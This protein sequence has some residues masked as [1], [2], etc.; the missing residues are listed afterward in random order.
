MK[1]IAVMTSGGDAPG[2][3]AAVRAIVRTASGFG[4]EVYGFYR[5]YQGIVDNDFTV[6]GP[7]DVGNIIQMGGT[8]LKT[9]RCKD[10]MTKEGFESAVKNLKKDKIDAL[11]VIGGNGTF[12]GAEE[13]NLAGI[14]VIGVPGT[15]DNDLGYTDRTI[16]FDTA[17]DTVVSLMNNVRD[18]VQAHERLTVVEVM[19]R[20]CGDIA[21]QTGIAC[22]A[23]LILVPEV[24]LTDKQI[25]DKLLR[26]R[27]S[28][29][30]ASIIVL[31]EGVGKAEDVLKIIKDQTGIDGRHLVVGYIQRG[32]SP[33]TIDRVLATRL[34][35]YAVKLL[36][37]GVYGVAVGEKNGKLVNVALKQA[38]SAVRKFDIDTYNLNDDVSV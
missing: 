11:I 21:L 35:N 20:K 33:T 32:G 5:G 9:S 36:R 27:E 3:N 24:K 22:G 17:V 29:K 12:R 25:C 14:K 18:T 7:R 34:G 2:M 16:G 4:I 30:K 38:V 6:L 1:R 37:D 23:D 19:G 15:I 26:S 10:F 8:F 31:A 13:L 28:G